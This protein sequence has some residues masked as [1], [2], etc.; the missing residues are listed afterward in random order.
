M[1]GT[2]RHLFSGAVIEELAGFSRGVVVNDQ[3]F[4]SSTIGIDDTTGELAN[5]VAAQTECA[6]DTI[7]VALREAEC[8]LADVVRIRIY[9]KRREDMRDVFAVL[10]RRTGAHYPA[11]TVILCELPHEDSLIEIEVDAVRLSGTPAA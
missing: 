8:S 11:N 4:L 7:E 9:L 10:K 5:G 6:L 3:V 2:R 1:E